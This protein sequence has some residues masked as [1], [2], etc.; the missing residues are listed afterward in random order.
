[1]EVEVVY[2]QAL[3]N[4]YEGVSGTVDWVK[5]ILYLLFF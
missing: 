2:V 5:K 3:L 1:M 4:E